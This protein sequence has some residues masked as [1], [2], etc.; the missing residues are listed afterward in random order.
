MV[1][2]NSAVTSRSRAC[3]FSVV[4][5]V[6]VELVCDTS[7][8]ASGVDPVPQGSGQAAETMTDE[9][10]SLRAVIESAPDFDLL[11]EMVGFAAQ[12]PMDVEIGELIARGAPRLW[13]TIS[14]SWALTAR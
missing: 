1:W 12:R 14:S 10:M 9:T 4:I 6:P 3:G 5:E 8:D 2:W 11:R 13:I 7:P